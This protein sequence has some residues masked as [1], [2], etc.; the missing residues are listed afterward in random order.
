MKH[1]FSIAASSVLL[2]VLLL[3]GCGGGGGGGNGATTPATS[4]LSGTASAGAPIIGTVT[5]RDSDPATADKT[6]TIAADGHYT[7]D[8][9][10]LTAPFMLRADGTVG[11]RSYSLFSAAAA[12]DVNGTIN[13]TPLTDLI[14]ANIAGQIAS[15][16]F[17][18]G[19][20]STLTTAALTAQEA[21]LRARLQPILAA[22][23]VIGAVD[24]LRSSFAANHT[25]LDAALDA[26]RVTVDPATNTATITSI[27]DSQQIIDDLASKTDATTFAPV[28]STNFATTLTELQQIVAR[29]DA[30]SALFATGLPQIT[31]ATLLGLLDPTFLLDG[32]D[33]DTFLSEITSDPTN[34]GIVFTGVSLV[35]GSMLPADAPTTAKVNFTVGQNGGSKDKQ[36]FTMNKV[37]SIWK[38]DGNRQIAQAKGRTFARLQDVF[39]NNALQTNHIDTGLIFEIKNPTAAGLASISATV[40]ANVSYYAIVTGKGLPAAGALYVGDFTQ[41]GNSFFAAAV[42]AAYT[43]PATTPR[44]SNFG[45]NQFPLLDSAITPLVDNE[46]YTIKIFQDNGTLTTTTDDVLLATYTSTPGKRPYLFSELSVAS[47]AAITAP[48]KTELTVF[49][50]TGGTITVSWTLPTTILGA[51]SDQLDYFRIGTTGSSD[52]VFL[53]LAFTATSVPLTILSPT[54][55]GIGTGPVQNNGINLDITDSF[56]RQLETI[57]NGN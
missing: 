27:I 54:A 8:V 45:F 44:L 23:G 25:G 6:V 4:T 51:K 15:N 18:A 22:A 41:T 56:N 47:F 46:I 39:I 52:N 37:G 31:N 43:G 30:L 11:G 10:G 17:N 36:E 20:F 48:T 29:F 49:A 7:V 55:A 16:F 53:S 21:V 1:S 19:N 50:N 40:P 33:H 24:L 5:I 42:G 26:L 3:A 38:L 57:Y 34:I 12:A 14:V 2:S 35:P 32:E 9:T 13:V 28:N